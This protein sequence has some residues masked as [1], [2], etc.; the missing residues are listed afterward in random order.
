MRLAPFQKLAVTIGAVLVVLGVIAGVSYY[1]ATRRAAADLL[2]E[3]ANANLSAAF[4]MVM[5]RQDGERATKA[6]VVRPDSVSRA[7]LQSAQVQVEEA[8]D[9]LSRGTDDHPR[10]RALLGQLAS[11]SAAS[12]E[13]FR[14]TV[15]IRDRAGADSARRFLSSEPSVIVA[16]SLMKVASQMR[17]EE[18]RVL[19]EQTRQQAA[20]GANAQRLIL[21]GMVLTFLLAGLAL[22]PMR[23]GVAKRMTSHFAREQISDAEELAETAQIHAAV[24]VAQL[25]ALHQV[26][27]ALADARDA[28]SGARV[29]A[30]GATATLGAALA[31]VIVP[32]GAGGLTVL[33][34][35]DGS[36]VSVSPALARPVAEI[37]RTGEAAMAESRVAREQRWGAMADLDDRGARGSALF[38]PLAAH[39]TVTGV[40]VIGH[41][42]D[43]VFGDDELT[44]TTTLGRLGGSVVASR[45][46]AS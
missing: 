1:Y 45:S 13:T 46:T 10:Q 36:F 27:A 8:L 23:Q 20:H 28:A 15:L 40:L 18:L 42:D 19:A 34:S 7:A 9:V 4:R 14:L 35:S 16:D 21:F 12:F 25:T 24:A 38:T 26:V 37:L 11:G 32:D 43:H 22:Q 41:A 2:V 5:A 44:F 39:G 3:R 30:D 33:A 31:A 29:I 17:D 6:Y